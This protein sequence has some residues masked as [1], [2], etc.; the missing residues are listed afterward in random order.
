MLF[1]AGNEVETEVGSREKD[2]VMD[3]VGHD[4]KRRRCQ[5]IIMPSGI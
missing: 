1:V 3:S 4:I 2:E 5:N